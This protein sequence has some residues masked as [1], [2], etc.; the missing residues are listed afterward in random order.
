MTRTSV[1]TRNRQSKKAAKKANTKPSN[2]ASKQA[3]ATASELADVM[4]RVLT[5]DP[6]M[7]AQDTLLQ[8][9]KAMGCAVLTPGQLDAAP[10][11]DDAAQSPTESVFKTLDGG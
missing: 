11:G 3:E 7:S 9:A 10:D 6:N 1:Q 5:A 4:G 8:M 2:G